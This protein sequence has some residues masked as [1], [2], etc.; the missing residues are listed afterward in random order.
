MTFFLALPVF[1]VVAALDITANLG[2][3]GVT[4]RHNAALFQAASSGANAR[5]VAWWTLIS[6]VVALAAS[7]LG[8]SLGARTPRSPSP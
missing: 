1:V 3:L 2:T 6:L 4:I 7:A 5:N 8:G